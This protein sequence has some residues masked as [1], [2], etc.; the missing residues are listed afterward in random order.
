MVGEMFQQVRS[1]LASIGRERRRRSHLI[2]VKICFDRDYRV[3]LGPNRSRAQP[4][5][6]AS[7]GAEQAGYLAQ[8]IGHRGNEP[9]SYPGILPENHTDLG[10][11]PNSSPQPC[12]SKE[13]ER[14]EKEEKH[15]EDSLQH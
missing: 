13:P 9:T 12:E 5:Q 10:L 14:S 8:V 11:S 3:A 7:C 4:S 2:P 6:L 15:C 1:L